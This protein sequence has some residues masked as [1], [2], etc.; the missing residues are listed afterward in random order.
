MARQIHRTT[1]SI[2]RWMNGTS[3]R[4][5]STLKPRPCINFICLRNVDLKEEEEK[6][7]KRSHAMIEKL[8]FQLQHC[9][10]TKT[11]SNK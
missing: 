8:T 4:F 11:I 5:S 7:Q 10:K 1:L 2:C 6:K 9:L 3:R